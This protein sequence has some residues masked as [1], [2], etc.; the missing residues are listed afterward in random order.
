MGNDQP[1]TVFEH[2]VGEIADGFVLGFDRAEQRD[3]WRGITELRND[4]FLRR[5]QL[6]QLLKVRDWR[7]AI[8]KV[9]CRT[10]T[11]MARTSSSRLFCCS[12]RADS[13]VIANRRRRRWESIRLRV[14]EQT[15]ACH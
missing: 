9:D 2:H 3:R 5:L 6:S 7:K 11:S 4:P 12:M 10:C 13:R 8:D 1:V 15:E 14:A